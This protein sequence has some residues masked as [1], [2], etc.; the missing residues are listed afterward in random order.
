VNKSIQIM[1]SIDHF[2]LWSFDLNLLIAFDAL[3][4]ERSV[5]RAAARLK[6]QQPAMSHN[7]KTLRLLFDDEL[8]V[9]V[10][11][12]MRPT[13]RALTLSASVN[14]I[15]EQAQNAITVREAFRPE[16]ERRTFAIGFSSEMEVLLMPGLTARVQ[17]AAPGI[18]LLARPA[19]PAQVH[20]LLDEGEIDL[21]IGCF[22]SGSERYRRRLLFEQSLMSCFN[23]RLLDL[24]TPIDRPTWLTQRHALVSQNASIR[25]CLDRALQAAGVELEMAMAAPEFLT[26]LSAAMQT[27]VLATLPARIVRRYAPLLG[28]AVSPVPLELRVMPIAMVWPTHTDSDP[29]SEWLRQQAMAVLAEVD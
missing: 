12:V 23:P 13:A 21:A 26:V 29:A 22:E 7:L 16:V 4:R 1:S 14:Q 9:R 15:L 27:P 25:G 5:T 24:P 18:N 19:Q 6:I 8:F 17:A 10:G 28:L 20:R 11:Q 3:M 2:N